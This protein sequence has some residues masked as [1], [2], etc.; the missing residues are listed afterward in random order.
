MAFVLT[1]SV[2]GSRSGGP[3]IFAAS[4]LEAA[5]ISAKRL[6][7]NINTTRGQVSVSLIMV[8]SP[9]GSNSSVRIK[10]KWGEAHPR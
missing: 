5:A 10:S 2:S 6:E 9:F 4:V 1:I 8:R 3:P 7:A